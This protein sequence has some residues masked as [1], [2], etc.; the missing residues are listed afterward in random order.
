MTEIYSFSSQSAASSNISSC[1]TNPLDFTQ[2]LA[3]I[4]R[5]FAMGYDE[6]QQSSSSGVLIAVVVA[7]LLIAVLGILAGVGFFFVRT[8]RVEAMV[9]HERAVAELHRAGV[10]AQRE[11]EE[12]RV[13]AT[14]ESRLNF[15]VKLDREGN[16]SVD[17]ENIDLDEL[18]E[19]LVK[20]KEDTSNAFSVQINADSECPV[21]HIVPVLDVCNEVGGVDFRI[22]SSRASESS[23]ESNA[24]N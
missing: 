7:V 24:G 1:E 16:A 11:V 4:Q 10:E 14:P 23:D 2:L 5:R 17:G 8:S 9:T 20:L 12:V 19:Q 21:K 13:E 22:V 3:V 15:A 6:R 18:K